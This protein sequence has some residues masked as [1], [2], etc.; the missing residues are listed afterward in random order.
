MN[1]MHPDDEENIADDE[2]TQASDNTDQQAESTATET[3]SIRQQ[4]SATTP[5]IINK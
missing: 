5:I 3:A 2:G 1:V 4:R